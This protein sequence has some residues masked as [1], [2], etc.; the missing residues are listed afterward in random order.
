M[1]WFRKGNDET[2][3]NC[4]CWWRPVID[5]K[6]SG[7]DVTYLFQEFFLKISQLRGLDTLESMYGIKVDNDTNNEWWWFFFVFK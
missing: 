5:R 3:T 1:E 7:V 6:K 2:F 4:E